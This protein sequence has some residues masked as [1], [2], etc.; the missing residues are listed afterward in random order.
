MSQYPEAL[1]VS[2]NNIQIYDYESPEDIDN[3]PRGLLLMWHPPESGAKY[4]MGM[5]PTQGITGWSRATRNPEDKKIDNGAIEVFQVDARRTQIMKEVPNPAGR[6]KIMVPD[7][8]ERKQPKYLYKDLQ[9]AEF[10]APCDAVELAQIANIIGRIYAGAEEDQC[11]LI[12][13]S[14]PG[15]GI[16]TTQELLRLGYG[17]LW[18]WEY[19][20]SVAEETNRMGW[21]STRESQKL[22]WYRSRRHLMNKQAIIR[23]RHLLSEYANAEIDMD[24]MRARAAYGFHDDRF[25]AANM[26]FWAGHSWCYDVERTDE[27]VTTSPQQ[28]YQRM[29]PDFNNF[30]SYSDW[31]QACCDAMEDD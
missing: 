1:Y 5:D 6:G 9:V 4:I 28:D 17:N 18:M 20:D 29:A 13:E 21:R 14:W 31:K 8:D 15:P 7:L 2:G 22:L 30:Q 19:I 10:A 16:L 12:W 11:E 3:D 27:R 25:Q 23:S 24:K 26:C